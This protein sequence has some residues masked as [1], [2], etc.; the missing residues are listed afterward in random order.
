MPSAPIIG[1]TATSEM[2]RDALRV[3]VNASYIRAVEEAGGVPIVLP[4]LD[5]L[6]G[7]SQLIDRMDALLLTGGED[8]DPARFNESRHPALGPVHDARDATEIELVT[9]AHERGEI[10]VTPL[11]NQASGS[12]VSMAR[13]DAL[14]C[15][16][17]ESS[18]LSAGDAV[19]VYPLRALGL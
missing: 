15:I 1:I 18:A 17:L 6:A 10:I 13:A 9:M 5:S 7:A 3:R 14:M 2:I 11:P 4:P 16:P 19:D 12:A 8:I